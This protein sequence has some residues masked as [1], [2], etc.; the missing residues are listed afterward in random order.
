MKQRSIEP[1]YFE[2]FRKA[3]PLPPGIVTYS[4]KPDVVLNG[5]QRVGIEIT[6]FYVTKGGSPNSE[7]VQSKRR[8]AAVATGQKLYQE[9]HG[10]NINLSFGFNKNHPIQDV[11]TL[12]KR[13]AALARKVEG[14]DNGQIR[15]NVFEDI[16][17]IDFAYLNARQ[18]QASAEP[19]P[20]FP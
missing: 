4:D 16:P 13:L 6:N 15:R 19:D 12:A 20:K 7:Q 5:K 2:M 11:P 17:E 10:K 14:W 18:L 8:K 3:Y 9:N 1:Y